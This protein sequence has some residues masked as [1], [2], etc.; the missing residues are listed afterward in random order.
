MLL[1]ALQHPGTARG[2]D[3]GATPRRPHRNAGLGS[4]SAGAACS[5]DDPKACP[6][7]CQKLLDGF[8]LNCKKGDPV[9]IP[10]ETV[11]SFGLKSF[12]GVVVE[13]STAYKLGNTRS[14]EAPA[15]CRQP[16]FD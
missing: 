8:P 13:V 4:P 5:T 14:L 15:S 16:N 10:A 1:R 12:S 3:S 6:A 7:A 2:D 9:A 11:E